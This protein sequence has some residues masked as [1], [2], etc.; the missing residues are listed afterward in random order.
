LPSPG[1]DSLVRGIDEIVGWSQREERLE[2][3]EENMRRHKMDP[4]DHK[5]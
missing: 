3:L 4:A 1:L 2:V 5:W